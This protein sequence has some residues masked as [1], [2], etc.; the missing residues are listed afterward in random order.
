MRMMKKLGAIL[1]LALILIPAGVM[2][3]GSQGNGGN[4]G[5]D[6]VSVSSS[7]V[8]ALTDEEIQWL[9]YMR[10]E[11]KLARD[12]YLSLYDEWNMHIFSNIAASEQKHTDAVKTLLVRYGIPDPAAGNARGEFTNPD[13]QDLCDHLIQQGNGSKVEAL[14]VGVFIEETDI[15]D[16]NAAIATTTHKDIKTVYNNLLQGS[17]NHLASFESQLPKI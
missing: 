17:F 16:L 7:T 15:D 1:L 3:A 12:V 6:G 9:T 5:N 8:T 13:L 2:A 11:E 10:E 4:Y 14:K